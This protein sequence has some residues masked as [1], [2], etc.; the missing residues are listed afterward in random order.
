MARLFS[1]DKYRT[2]IERV[3]H[4]IIELERPMI[5]FVLLFSPRERERARCDIFLGHRNFLSLERPSR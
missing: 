2:P 5:A 3:I 1:V 4:G